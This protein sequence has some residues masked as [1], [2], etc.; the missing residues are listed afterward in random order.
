MELDT[1]VV[2]L[3]IFGLLIGATLGALGVHWIREH[4][5]H[6]WPGYRKG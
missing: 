1:L 6:W 4:R 3:P 2:V 5:P